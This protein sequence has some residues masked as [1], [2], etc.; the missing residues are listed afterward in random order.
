MK[1]ITTKPKL[2]KRL[3]SYGALASSL[4]GIAEANGQIVYTD[5]NPDYAGGNNISYMIDLDNNGV[6]DFTIRQEHSYYNWYGYIYSYNYL[7]MDPLVAGNYIVGSIGGTS[8][9]FAYPFALSSNVTIS[10][11]MTGWYNNGYNSGFTS[12][13]WNGGFGNFIG[14]TDKFIGVQFKI[15][16]NTH[17]GWI[18]MDVSV[19]PT[20]WTI[21]DFAYNAT[22]DATITTPQ[23]L[24][25]TSEATKSIKIVSLNHS[26]ALYNL[27]Q[28]ATYK[29]IN[30]S[31][32]TITTGTVSGT[33]SYVIETGNT[34]A[35]GI[36]IVE[37]QDVE[38]Q[39]ILRKKVIL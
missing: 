33:D 35:A 32:Q 23:V 12:L 13:N 2:S 21:K 3:V 1:K 5:V 16:T 9:Q 15:G 26:V 24:S 14:V 39:S 38:T 17:Y 29:L 34:L 27:P 30:M 22:P 7:Y 8:N 37:V 36:Y 25:T 19:N 6:N 10:S 28:Q 11:G 18:R 4:A 31:G 20:S